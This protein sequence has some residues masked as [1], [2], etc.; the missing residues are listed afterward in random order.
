MR[1]RSD[2]SRTSHACHVYETSSL[3][4][5]IWL[6]QCLGLWTEQIA[7]SPLKWKGTHGPEESNEILYFASESLVYYEVYHFTGYL[8]QSQISLALAISNYF[9]SFDPKTN[10][11]LKFAF[12]SVN[13]YLS[14]DFDLSPDITLM[15][16]S[17]HGPSGLS[18][19]CPPWLLPQKCP[20]LC[21]AAGCPNRLERAGNILAD[22]TNRMLSAGGI[23]GTPRNVGAL[24]TG[25]T[26]MTNAFLH[27]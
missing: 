3:R 6:R 17:Q 16:Q 1:T 8:G 13:S 25:F 7:E 12:L 2:P 24:K 5:S 9:G 26:Y 18:K 20:F 11:D 27:S 22:W 23:W 4:F 19:T 21:L 10:P 15:P 14:V